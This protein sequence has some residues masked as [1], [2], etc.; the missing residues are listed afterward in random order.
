MNSY[1][2]SGVSRFQMTK[3]HRGHWH[4]PDHDP[5]PLI[6]EPPPEATKTAFVSRSKRPQNASTIVARIVT[7]WP[8]LRAARL[9][10]RPPAAPDSELEKIGPWAGPKA[11]LNYT[12]PFLGW[13][14]LNAS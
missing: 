9:G 6:H 3:N 5:M 2:N 1:M 10:F 8:I 11:L 14:N 4:C 13:Q 7:R 12:M